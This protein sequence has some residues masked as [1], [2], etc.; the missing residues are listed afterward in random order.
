MATSLNLPERFVLPDLLRLTDSVFELK[1]SPFQEQARRVGQEWFSLFGHFDD[2]KLSSYL[3]TGKYD[4]FVA[5]GFPNTLD[6]IRLETCMFYALWAFAAD[7]I[8]DEGELQAQPLDVQAGID[9]SATVIDRL[10]IHRPLDPCA[11]MLQ[12]ILERIR[13]SASPQVYTRR[14]CT[15]WVAWTQGQV[16]QTTNRSQ[17]VVPSVE[18]FITLRRATIAGRMVEA[19]V[20]YALDLDIPDDVFAHPALKDISDVVIDLIAWANDLCSFNVRDPSFK[21]QADGDFSNLV[22]VLMVNR[23]IDLQTA[24][25]VLTAMYGDRVKDY[26][27][28]KHELPSFGA[29]VDTQ[30]VVYW[31]NM[32][33]FFQGTVKWYYSSPRYF[34]PAGVPHVDG[35]LEIEL[36]P[37]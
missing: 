21:E 29:A 11:A 15:G 7:D 4:L 10:D 9:I 13:I 22:F 20:Q 16:K 3:E 26:T 14:F 5:L 37:R 36:L 28:L 27:Q 25:N 33:H 35:D 17:S 18:E 31:K 12:D 34:P 2:M 6:A 24:V 8:T 1:I 32:E 23:Q 19:M 30:L